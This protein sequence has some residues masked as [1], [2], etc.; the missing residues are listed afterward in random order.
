MRV[1][2]VDEWL[3][4]L[5]KPELQVT[6]VPLLGSGDVLLMCAGFED[7]AIEA[8]ARAVRNGCCGFRVLC[9]EYL[10]SIPENRSAVIAEFCSTAKATIEILPFNREHPAGAAERLLD[11][12]SDAE[13]LHVD[14]SGMSRLLIVQL[15]AAIVRGKRAGRVE[16]LYCSAHDYP[17]TREQVQASLSEPTDLVGVTMFVSTGVFGLTIV[18][19]LSSVAMQ[20]QPMRVI[21]FPSWNTT[22]LAAV[23]SEMQASYFTIV[24]GVPPDPQYM[25]RRDAIR[26]LNRVDSLPAL[27]EIDVS[28]LDYRETLNMLLDVYKLH[29]QREKLIVSPTGSK[30]Q[31][32]AVG[33]TC[34]FLRDLQ[35]A[36]PTPRSFAAPAEYTRGVGQ[37]YR[38]PLALFV[39]PAELVC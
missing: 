36:Y 9:I 35:V 38:L 21:A 15:V 1:C 30:M 37:L 6:D 31:S 12:V 29:G 28:T 27:Q 23:C 3:R 10:P 39:A 33:I 2:R 7:R 16:I 26:V 13:Y 17:P 22:Q 8:L 18:P 24:H 5:A 19:E 11:C 4:Q 32:L 34:G 14:L 20:G 25:W